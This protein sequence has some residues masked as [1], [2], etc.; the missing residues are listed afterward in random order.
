MKNRGRIGTLCLLLLAGLAAQSVYGQDGTATISILPPAPSQLA[1]QDV[2]VAV[3]FQHTGST[4]ALTVDIEFDPAF[5]SNVDLSDCVSIISS[6]QNAADCFIRNAPNDDQI[7]ITLLNVPTPAE[8]V[9]G[10]FGTIT[11]TIDE[12]QLPGSESDL[13]IIPEQ[14]VIEDNPTLVLNN[15]TITVSAGPSSVDF[16]PNPGATID[17]G[18]AE[19]NGGTT[20]EQVQI[21]NDGSTGSVLNITDVTVSGTPFTQDGNC[22]SAALTAGGADDCCGIT[23]TFAPEATGPFNGSLTIETDAAGGEGTDGDGTFALTGTGT[24]GPAPALEIS[25]ASPFDF[26]ATDPGTPVEQVFTV[27]NNGQADSS[28]GITAFA[29]TGGEFSVVDDADTTCEANTTTLAQGASCAIKVAFEPTAAGSQTGS[30]TV[31]ADDEVNQTELTPL[32]VALEGVGNGPIFSSAPNPGNVDLGFAGAEGELDLDVVV[33][34]AGNQELE[35]QCV[36]TVDEGDVF[37]IDP[38]NLSV[39]PDASASF[40]V[41]CSLPDLET[42][43]ATLSCGTNDPANDIVEY[44]FSCS[45]LEPLPVPTMSNWSIALFA[46]LMLLVGGFSIRFF[47]T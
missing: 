25:P 27:T 40:N 9:D 41:A 3:N 4:E 20:T 33:S 19:Q 37:T 17:F 29:A 24:L 47:R 7:R 43:T 22:D 11:F 14:V 23:L 1:G 36:E 10:D 45:G 5:Y 2:E 13:T 28:A 26:G 16:T 38:L 8:V 39:D 42:Y 32:V 15:S 31:S 35:L 34:N 18:S 12:N 6:T 44:T 46:M 21:C 30:L